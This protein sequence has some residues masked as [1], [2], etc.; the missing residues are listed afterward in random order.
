VISAYQPAEVVELAF[1]SQYRCTVEAGLWS[2][3]KPEDPATDQKRQQ[4]LVTK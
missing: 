2:F 1:V 3:F 4:A